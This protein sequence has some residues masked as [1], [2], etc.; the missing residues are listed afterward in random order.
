[1]ILESDTMVTPRRHGW[2]RLCVCVSVKPL[3]C[4]FSLICMHS[5]SWFCLLDVLL[6]DPP[7]VGMLLGGGFASVRAVA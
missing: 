1:M 2:T 3:V 7:G 5:E 6:Q 4:V